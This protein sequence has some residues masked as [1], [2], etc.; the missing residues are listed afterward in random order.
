[1]SSAHTGLVTWLPRLSVA[2]TSVL[3]LVGCGISADSRPPDAEVEADTIRLSE[4][5]VRL[6]RYATRTLSADLSHL[7]PGDRAAIRMLIQAAKE[8]DDVFW[9]QAYGDPETL[10]ADLDPNERRLAELNHGPW[11]RLDDHHPVLPGTEPRPPGA[12]FYPAGIIRTDVESVTESGADDLLSPFTMVHL[13]DFAGLRSV[14]YHVEFRAQHDIAASMLDEAAKLVTDQALSS[15]LH[16]RG[17]A[18]R[19]DMYQDSDSAWSELRQN[20]VDIVIGPIEF[21]EDGLLG[22]KAAHTGLVLL[23]DAGWQSRISRYQ[24]HLPTLLQTLPVPEEYR[25][26]KSG[27]A[28]DL[29]V[30]DVLFASGAANA[31]F[32][33]TVVD[34]PH[35]STVRADG[36]TR[37]LYLK[38][39]QQAEFEEFVRPMTDVLLGPD[40]RPLV[41][42]EAFFTNRVL[43]ELARSLGPSE[44]VGG[45]GSV[46]LALRTYHAAIEEAK[47]AV[48]G[49]LLAQQLIE[50]GELDSSREAHY[51]TYVAS[52][53]H[54]GRPGT[55]EQDQQASM[56]QFAYLMEQ[57][58]VTRD[59]A[60]E[61]YRID[62]ERMET[63]TAALAEFL[64]RM[65]GEGNYAG[66]GRILSERGVVPPA[67]LAD[68]A[69]VSSLGV[70]TALAFVQGWE[71][72]RSANPVN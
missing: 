61:F 65:Q 6:S 9:I 22:A 53:I 48:M 24:D 68:L 36:R 38:N 15:F 4:A 44:T 28:S 49:V 17:E 12:N 31:G 64:L 72:L 23:R 34:L 52:L 59:D 67:L 26:S 33:S 7:E 60:T 35:D 2:L 54:D 41:M 5:E 58:A 37:S 18:L 51:A 45:E 14:P 3:L 40:Q 46:Q 39:V 56:V 1:M 71:H 66:A 20:A 55:E 19:T 69:K 8:M 43:Q 47:A 11:D 30:F 27:P 42:F 10:L 70:P 63:A 21:A 50:R 57:D 62:F 25:M 13:D 32:K 16:L 29:G